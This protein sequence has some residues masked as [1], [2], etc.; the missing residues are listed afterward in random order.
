V[1]TEPIRYFNI[2]GINYDAEMSTKNEFDDIPELVAY[3]SDSGSETYENPTFET[4]STHV[5]GDTQ[6]T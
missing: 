3:E 5:Y 2:E 4:E 1:Y 6:N